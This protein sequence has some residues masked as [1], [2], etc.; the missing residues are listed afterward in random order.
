VLTEK[1]RIVIFSSDGMKR[2]V[3]EVGTHVDLI[4]P[5]P[6][7]DMLFLKSRSRK[8]IE[9]ITVDFI[10]KINVSGSPSKGPADAPVVVAVFTDFECGYCAR[11]AK[12]VEKVLEQYPK[13]V[14]VVFKNFPLRNHKFSLEAAKAALAADAQGKFWEFHDRLFKN[15]HRLSSGKIQQIARELGLNEAQ[16]EK[17]RQDPSIPG[18][19]RR[20]IQDGVRAGVSGTPTVFINGRKLRAR[21]LYG[22]QVLIDKALKKIKKGKREP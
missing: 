7:E 13:E 12:T 10:Q 11:L 1:G 17:Q 19:I 5:G 20:D 3:I 16:F 2:G 21:S 6:M 9:I 15:Y 4:E 22:F 18:R 14:R 8:T